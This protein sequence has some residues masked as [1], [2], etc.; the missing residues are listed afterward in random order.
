M[1]YE[2][3]SRIGDYEI[4]QILGAGGMGKVFKVRNVISD[5]V[6][7]MKVLLPNLD[8]N[9]ELADRFIREIK[10]Q[11]SLNHPN[12]ANLHTALSLDNQLIMLMEYVEGQTLDIVVKDGPLP[13]AQMTGYAMQALEALSYAHGKGVV[14]RDLKPSNMMVTAQGQLKLL[15]FGIAKLTTE[16]ALTKTGLTVGSIYYMSPEQIQGAA[17]L[18]SRADLYSFGICLYE[19][20]TAR[21]PFEGDSEYSIM[22]AHLQQVPVPPIE[23]DPRLPSALNDVI[24]MAI[25]KDP[26]KRFQS[27][28]AMLGAL[29]AISGGMQAP[30]A[31]PQPARA[32]SPPPPPPPAYSAAPPPQ[33][34]PLPAVQPAGR[35]GLYMALGALA[36]VAVIVVAAIEIP[37]RMKTEAQGPLP[38]EASSPAQSAPV[39]PSTPAEPTPTSQPQTEQAAQTQPAAMPPVKTYSGQPAARPAGTASP[40]SSPSAPAA[41]T[42]P[43]QSQFASQAPS[44]PAQP[45][46]AQAAPGPNPADA[47]RQASL[48]ETRE[49]LMLLGTRAVAVKTSINT[50]RAEQQRMG[51]GLR[52]DISGGLQR[53]EY[54]LDQ[55]EDAL[56]RGDADAAKKNLSNAERETGKLESF[57]GR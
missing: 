46:P 34:A 31:P 2:I 3:G 54:F 21:R 26:A 10:V 32:P 17:T 47:A 27:A 19:L 6:E 14:H 53:M 33:P 4:L 18:D 55:T 49:H 16:T 56:K 5:R 40:S 57:L 29:R 1:N 50:L 15:D 12:I 37:K 23:R 24:L 43:G 44:Q 13:L 35:R 20:F 48:A 39:Q 36:A 7:A 52:S 42:Q 25:E 28:G 45:A 41:S 9:T 51:L 22:S 30:V 8:G 38:I 11:A